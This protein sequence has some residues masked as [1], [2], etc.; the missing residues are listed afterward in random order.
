MNGLVIIPALLLGL[1]SS[2]HCLGM[3]GGIMGGFMMML[4]PGISPL[5]RLILAGCYNLG[6]IGIYAVLGCLAAMMGSKAFAIFIPGNGFTIARV[7]AAVLLG[8]SGI[9]MLL[10]LPAGVWINRQMQPLWHYMQDHGGL[11]HLQPGRS[12]LHAILYGSLWGLLPC[13]LVYTALAYA[14]LA[15]DIISGGLAMLGFGLGTLPALL[16]PAVLP[17]R[18]Q[19]MLLRR[20][21]GGILVGYAG[22]ALF[23]LGDHGSALCLIR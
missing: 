9:S 6:R 15:P 1:A 7:I 12:V 16:A 13:G 5:R 11:H 4:P 22:F 19:S 10:C 8:I 2:L 20:I 21:L 17:M 23:W 18:G 3:C 14:I